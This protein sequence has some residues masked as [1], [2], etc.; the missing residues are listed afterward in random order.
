MRHRSG[1]RWLNNYLPRLKY[2]MRAC[3]F[4]CVAERETITAVPRIGAIQLGLYLI[5]RAVQKIIRR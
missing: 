4:V 3:V 1:K 5:R 2:F